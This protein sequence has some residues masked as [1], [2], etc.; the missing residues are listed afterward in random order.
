MR[1]GGVGGELLVDCHTMCMKN[2]LEEMSKL[3]SSGEKDLLNI[4]GE[5]NEGNCE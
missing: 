3:V 4:R 5:D 2:L 1:G